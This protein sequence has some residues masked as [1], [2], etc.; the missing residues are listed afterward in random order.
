MRSVVDRNVGMRRIIVYVCT[1]L[2]RTL[3]TFPAYKCFRLLMKNVW[4]NKKINNN[5]KRSCANNKIHLLLMLRHHSHKANY[6]DS[7]INLNKL[8]FFRAFPSVVRQMPGQNSPRR[9]TARAVP[10]TFLCCSM[11]CFLC[12][13]V[14]CLFVFFCRSLYCLCVNVY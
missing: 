7:R 5:N 14:Y 10:I 2:F 13:S 8:R 9:S 4:F 3:G 6:R 11:Y 1:Y 12:C